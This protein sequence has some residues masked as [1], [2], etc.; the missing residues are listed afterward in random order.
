MPL[1]LLA[2]QKSLKF[3]CSHSQM[4]NSYSK[5]FL[6]IHSETSEKETFF[7]KAACFGFAVLLK[8][9]FTNILRNRFFTERS[10]ISKT[11]V[12][13]LFMTY[14]ISLLN[15]FSWFYLAFQNCFFRNE[16][17]KINQHSWFL[18]SWL[19]SFY[20]TY[21]MW[22]VSK[23][24]VFF[25]QCYIPFSHCFHPI[26][27]CFCSSFYLWWSLILHFPATETKLFSC[28]C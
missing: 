20:I 27:N 11:V 19:Q 8:N 16:L 17:A 1:G 24:G 3:R 9:S 15:I 4:P 14:V 28:L 25:T 23:Y 22:K 10:M 13:M 6:R 26:S 2:G 12:G 21:T 7:S 18:E 5:Q